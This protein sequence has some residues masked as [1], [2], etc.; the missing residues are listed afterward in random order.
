MRKSDSEKRSLSRLVLQ[1]VL[2]R[3]FEMVR[4]ALLDQNRIGV[5]SG[6][7]RRLRGLVAR[8]TPGTASIVRHG[9]FG[10][11]RMKP[12]LTSSRSRFRRSLGLLRF[13]FL[14]A[15]RFR[16]GTYSFF[17]LRLTILPSLAV[18]FAL[19]R[20]C[21]FAGIPTPGRCSL[22]YPAPPRIAIHRG[23][24]RRELVTSTAMVRQ[25]LVTNVLRARDSWRP[26]APLFRSYR[27][28]R[29]NVT[30]PTERK[31]IL[32]VVAT[33]QPPRD[34]VVDVQ[35]SVPLLELLSAVLAFIAIPFSRTTGLFFPVRSAKPR[36]FAFVVENVASG[37]SASRQTS[38]AV[39][40]KLRGLGLRSNPLF[41]FT[42]PP[43]GN[44]YSRTARKSGAL[45]R[46]EPRT[47][48]LYAL[49]RKLVSTLRTVAR[50]LCVSVVGVASLRTVFPRLGFFRNRLSAELTRAGHSLNLSTQ[51]SRQKMLGRECRFSLV[52]RR[53][54]GYSPIGII[55][56]IACG[57]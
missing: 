36:A 37:L 52:S 34:Y 7:S 29:L 51:V 16:V 26:L 45:P 1:F 53:S 40:A 54:N 18:R 57:G 32:Q 21:H 8:A 27:G 46:T 3:P 39:G 15:I 43:A 24:L 23:V 42:A 47:F 55:P 13:S 19:D 50:S 44:D 48:A 33:A 38:A 31:Q 12:I 10:R 4:S 9:I 5:H 28:V 2:A 22:A 30:L 11:E 14:S 49:S 41:L 17:V 35:R 20:V 56:A 25:W 6:A